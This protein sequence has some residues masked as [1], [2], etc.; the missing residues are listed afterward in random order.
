MIYITGDTHGD[1]TRFNTDIFPEQQQMTK[2]DYVIVCGDFGIWQDTPRERQTL[3]WLNDKPFT[4]L[5][6][7]GNHSNFDRLYQMPV[8]EWNGGQ[9]HYIRDSIIHLMRG[10]VFEIAG[11]CVFT[12]GGATSH[13]I[14]GGILEPD[15]PDF[16]QKRKALDGKMAL[17]RVNHVS[18][19]GEELP[20]AE[21]YE[22][23]RKNLDACGWKVD[24]IITHCCPSSIED[25]LG[26]GL[27]QP[28]KLTEFFEEVK[29]QCRFEY[30]FFGHYHD[31]RV[32]MR[33]YI[34][35]Y[36]QIVEIER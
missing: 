35:L 10:Q 1:F 34:M 25:I 4:T 3:D 33:K 15:D 36:E 8:S 21:E 27:Y 26:G 12:M 13:D 24:Y 14:S 31:N 30:W 7:D 22:T 29:G 19:W 2:D 16:K 23:A 5:F 6:V 20:S 32:L 17:Y 28:D 9:V 11:K 18:W